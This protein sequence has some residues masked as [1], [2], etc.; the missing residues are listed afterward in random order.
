MGAVA[1]LAVIGVT[2]AVTLTVAD[3]GN[4]GGGS[5]TDTP[6]SITGAAN[7]DIASANDTGPVA[8]ITEDPSCAAARPIINTWVSKTKNG[9]EGR[10]SSIPATAWTPEVRN[11]YEEAG[12]A[13]TVA[14]DQMLPLAKLSPHRVMRELYSQFMAYAR[15]YADNIPTYS[16]PVD[17]LARVTNGAADSIANI[18][19]AIDFG[20]AAARGPFVTRLAEPTEVAPI[21]DLAQPQ[22]FLTGPNPVCMDWDTAVTQFADETVDWR[23]VNP[24]IS[25]GEW[26]PEQKAVN[27]Q[28]IPIMK[29]LASQLNVL[30]DRS[31]SPIF[32]DFAQLSV[33]YRR[34][35]AEAVPTYTPADD[36][37]A[38]A[39]A[40][41]SGMVNSACRAVSS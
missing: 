35:I 39:A 28:V 7:P 16:P 17:H 10:D 30:G 21:G 1:L 34:A 40:S 41:L 27:E 12:Q 24:E 5:P 3:K 25:A 38:T 29:R 4:G 26:T 8:V 33:Q 32:R 11:Q 13:M 14:A 19:A 20:S 31:E 18:C 15:A 37:L 6:Q 23:K 2:A 22:R 9:W 36:Y